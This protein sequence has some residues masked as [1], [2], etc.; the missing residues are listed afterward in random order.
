MQVG[1]PGNIDKGYCIKCRT[2]LVVELPDKI[3]FLC[4]DCVR[5]VNKMV[6]AAKGNPN[7]K[8]MVLQPGQWRKVNPDGKKE[9]L[10]AVKRR[11]K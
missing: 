9:P 5:E 3:R 6:Q 7:M 1:P 10:V 4:T 2:P 8:R 11:K